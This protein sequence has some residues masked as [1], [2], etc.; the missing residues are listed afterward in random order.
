[1]TTVLRYLLALCCSLAIGGC[2]NRTALPQQPDTFT[3]LVVNSNSALPRYEV[4]VQAFLKTIKGAELVTVDLGEDELPTETLQDM[5]N[6]HRVQAI[7]CVG[8][9]ALGSIDYLSPATPVVYSSVLSWREF[10]SRKHFYG[11]TDGVAPAAQLAWFKHFFPNIQRIG[12][13]Y[14][15]TSENVLKDARH[16]A[17]A[18]SLT[19]NTRKIA[20]GEART[21]HI[22]ALLESS[23]AI[24]ILPDP[25]VLDSE[26]NTVQLFEQAHRRKI[27][28]FAYNPFFMELGAT[29][30]INADLATT[31]RQAA[32]MVQSLQNAAPESNIQFP[33]GSNV[34][35]N[36]RKVREYQLNLD[37]DAL[38]SVSELLDQ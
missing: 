3:V 16:S 35:L 4:P 24:W 34:S 20:A 6:A 38:N 32:L 12:V 18:L 21:P 26:A 36:L 22:E 15:D 33:A 27:P 1:M 11:V 28:V 23:D 29:L 9:K 30:S 37:S 17:E 5:L 31:G 10:Q 25:E 14:S 7:Y 19:L 8:A 2:Q 13:L